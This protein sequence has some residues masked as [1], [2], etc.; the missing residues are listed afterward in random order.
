MSHTATQLAV[1]NARWR[2]GRVVAIRAERWAAGP[3]LRATRLSSLS[4]P[5][6]C[7][8]S[9]APDG[10]SRR[11]KSVRSSLSLPPSLGGR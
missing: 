4:R 2:P 10:E 9:P 5:P 7:S 6:A 1:R 8:A 3:I 11:P